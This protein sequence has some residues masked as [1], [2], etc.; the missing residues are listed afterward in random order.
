M[1]K[2]VAGNRGAPRRASTE[3]KDKEV[4]V[5]EDNKKRGWGEPRGS[6]KKDLVYLVSLG[7]VG[8]REKIPGW[9]QPKIGGR[10]VI[11]KKMF[12]RAKLNQSCVTG[13]YR[14]K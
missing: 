14:Q 12:I 1:E 8:K 3:K 6:K 10:K 9:W 11:R 5:I 13:E 4:L 7:A 2:G